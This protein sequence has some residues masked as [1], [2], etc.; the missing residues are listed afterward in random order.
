MVRH[1][2]S[3]RPAWFTRT[4]SFSVPPSSFLRPPNSGGLVR[5]AGT[6]RPHTSQRSGSSVSP[7]SRCG[8]G[9][10]GSLIICRLWCSSPIPFRGSVTI[11]HS[12]CQIGNARIWHRSWRGTQ[13]DTCRGQADVRLLC[14]LRKLFARADPTENTRLPAQ[15]IISYSLHSGVL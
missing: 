9:E 2:L 1:P 11:M 15:S 8:D 14:L 7:P 12:A 13:V 6:R 4:T 3:R 10:S 5:R